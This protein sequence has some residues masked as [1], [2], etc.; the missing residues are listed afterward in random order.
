MRAF[1]LMVVG[2]LLVA[3]AYSPQQIV[4]SPNLGN[5]GERYGNSRPIAVAA[6]DNRPVKEL[7]SRG[8]VYSETSLISISNNLAEAVARSAEAKLAT[9]G[10]SI[11]SDQTPA[12]NLNI[13]VESLT[14]NAV[15]DS[16]GQKLEL[17]AVVKAQLSSGTETFNGT[18][19]S[20][21]EKTAVV[22]PS[23]ATNEKMVN[24]LLSDTLNRM[25]ADPKFQA[26]LSNI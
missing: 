5:D 2:L 23:I 24:D 21:F 1:A 6:E 20:R 14:Y 22:A 17:S 15:D 13:T 19:K 18:Y 10:F 16:V 7:G 26:F 8:G 12:A 25:F 4:V 9:Q 3:C 11:N